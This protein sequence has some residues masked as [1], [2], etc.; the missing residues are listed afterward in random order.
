MNNNRINNGI[1]SQA[2]DSAYELDRNFNEEINSVGTLLESLK[3]IKDYSFLEKPTRSMPRGIIDILNT[4]KKKASYFIGLGKRIEDEVGRL[5][6]NAERD[7]KTIQQLNATPI[8]DVDLLEIHKLENR[9]KNTSDQVMKLIGELKNL[10]FSL[11][12]MV[13]ILSFI[14]ALPLGE[15]I[16][17]QAI[18]AGLS[19]L[20]S[21]LS[22]DTLNDIQKL[23]NITENNYK[24]LQ[25][26]KVRKYEYLQ[27]QKEGTA[28]YEELQKQY[29]T[30]QKEYNDMKAQY[31][32]QKKDIEVCEN[33]FVELQKAYDILKAKCEPKPEPKKPEEKYSDEFNI[34]GTYNSTIT[35]EPGNKSVY[36]GPV[37]FYHTKY[38]VTG[39][40]EDET[41]FFS[42]YSYQHPTQPKGYLVVKGDAA[43][44]KT[45]N[46]GTFELYFR[47]GPGRI[48]YQ[49]TIYWDNNKRW[50]INGL[51]EQLIS[52]YY[53][54]FYY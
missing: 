40:T 33:K 34:S 18:L 26:I 22:G 11:G 5:S 37:R 38:T 21:M 50:H 53:R 47:N 43:D 24:A 15:A 31:E 13:P 39:N 36:S 35:S 44:T 4:I 41:L 42:G 45:G 3:N 46:R 6:S 30:L 1:M 28:K 25:D 49:G 52:N 19:T 7:R 20:Y 32:K 17:A 48:A 23:L 54:P 14:A 29:K 51:S 2:E 9:F 16:G 12:V 10:P 8:K 27:A